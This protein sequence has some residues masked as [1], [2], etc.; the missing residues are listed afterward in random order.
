MRRNKF[1]LY[2]TD[3]LRHMYASGQ[4]LPGVSQDELVAEIRRRLRWGSR[5]A[6]ILMLLAIAVL[7]LALSSLTRVRALFVLLEPPLAAH[8]VERPP[9]TGALPG[10]APR[11]PPIVVLL[12]DDIASAA[13]PAW[14]DLVAG[15]G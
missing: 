8:V 12:L 1:D 11:R 4:R 2:T 13:E 6:L 3:D 5:Y 9:F 10:G 7:A 15:V 14:P